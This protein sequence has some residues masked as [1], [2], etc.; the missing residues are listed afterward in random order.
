M[1]VERTQGL[2]ARL[3]AAFGRHTLPPAPV[4]LYRQLEQVVDVG[5]P[6]VAPR[7]RRFV[8]LAAILL[9][10][11]LVL[12][13]FVGIVLLSSA[14]AAAPDAEAS[15]RA[16]AITSV[17]GLPVRGVGAVLALRQA[18]ELRNQPVVVGGYWTNRSRM[19]SCAPPPGQPGLLEHYCS[20]GE[21]GITE[22]N[23]PIL[24]FV[25]PARAVPATGPSLTP[26]FDNELIRGDVVFASQFGLELPPLPIVVR[27]HFDDP[28]VSDCR[29]EARQLCLD[30]LVVDRVVLFDIE[31]AWA[32]TPPLVPATGA[33]GVERPAPF[34]PGDCPQVADPGFVGWTVPAAIGVPD[35]A[36]LVWVMVSRVDEVVFG[37]WAD[38]PA[39]SGRQV[40]MLAKQMCAA[41]ASDELV[42][43]GPLPTSIY[44]EWS[45]GTFTRIGAHASRP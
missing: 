19:H 17:D 32:A 25:E 12:L 42:T 30:R 22:R 26:H 29:P 4:R 7:R 10:L 34:G 33:D 13:T 1:T 24:R 6:R 35:E 36:G 18:G 31:A 20:D 38:D 23:E 41:R 21:Y 40:R 2:E 9:L 15:P 8:A 5:H 43:R 27:G 16:T 28:R 39:G 37:D 45:D 11:V 44:L 14:P 3:T